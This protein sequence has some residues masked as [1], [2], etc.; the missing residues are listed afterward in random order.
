M[1]VIPGNLSIATKFGK[2]EKCQLMSSQGPEEGVA[3]HET[4]M[5]LQGDLVYLY[6]PLQEAPSSEN[7][8]DTVPE[9]LSMELDKVFENALS[10]IEIP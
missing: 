1:V 3:V 2:R 9:P 7:V 10:V 6:V 5:G 4:S 8:P